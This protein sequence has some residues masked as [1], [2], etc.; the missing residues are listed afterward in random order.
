MIV[1][2]SV[3]FWIKYSTAKKVWIRISNTDGTVPVDTVNNEYG[4]VYC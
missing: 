2:S 4:N 1:T 3:R